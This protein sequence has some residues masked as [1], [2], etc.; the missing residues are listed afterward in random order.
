MKIKKIIL[1]VLFIL[2]SFLMGFFI[3][4]TFF[5]PEPPTQI[6]VREQVVA[7]G[8]LPQIGIGGPKSLEQIEQEQKEQ[9]RIIKESQEIDEF[10]NGGLTS[11]KELISNSIKGISFNTDSNGISYYDP[12]QQAFFRIK[13][14]GTI[15]R[16][17]DK[18]FYYVQNVTWSDKKDRA[19]L[20]YPDGTKILYDFD[21]DKQLVT[22][23]KD[24]KEFDFSFSEEKIASKWVGQYEDYN[25]LVTVNPDGSGL[26]F[27]EPMGDQERNVAVVWSPDNEVLATYRKY[28]DSERQEIFFIN[29]YGKNLKSLVVEGGGFKGEWSPSG[30]NLVYSVYN[31]ASNYKP[32]LWV[33]NGESD[34]LGSGKTYLNLNTWVDKCD[35]S[36]T[37]SNSMYCAV[38]DSL[39]EGSGLSPSVANGSLYSIYKINLETG[40]KEKISEPV[41]NGQRVSINK[42]YLDS[43]DRKLYY[44]NESNGY[45]YS[46]DLQP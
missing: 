35:F 13:E 3:Y 27:I 46:I 5:K 41:Y 4:S 40:V 7:T 8:T 28:I 38:P 2:V 29:E 32:T 24:M 19:I 25:Y 18:K 9:E 21:K 30:K 37:N 26:K 6:P 23:P 39:P 12:N 33:A 20:E 10:A 42:I 16:L 11:S 17:S 15:E 36:K 31:S 1:I 14:D 44:T 43:N 45:L 34:G 22:F